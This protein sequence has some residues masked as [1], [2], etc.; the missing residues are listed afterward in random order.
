MEY[1]TPILVIFPILVLLSPILIT[2]FPIWSPVLFNPIPLGQQILHYYNLIFDD[3]IATSTDNE[4]CDA[5][6]MIVRTY[7]KIVEHRM[8]GQRVN[9]IFLLSDAQDLWLVTDGV[10]FKR[11]LFKH[12][13]FI[14][15]ISERIERNAS[16]VQ[17]G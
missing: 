9:M 12:L 5:Y 11:K 13:A 4:V 17:V 6:L 8:R 1:L 10:E 15:K 16:N 2:L 7:K 14:N 3:H